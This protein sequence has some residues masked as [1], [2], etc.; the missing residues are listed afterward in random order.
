VSGAFHTLV[1]IDDVPV[2]AAL[3][4]LASAGWR[5]AGP[6]IWEDPTGAVIRL[7]NHPASGVQLIEVE[8]SEADEITRRIAAV[9]PTWTLDAVDRRVRHAAGPEIMLHAIRRLGLLPH[10]PP[11]N[12]AARGYVD[13]WSRTLHHPDRHVRLETLRA[14]RYRSP[15]LLRALLADAELDEPDNEV[16]AEIRRTLDTI[17]AAAAPP[18]DEKVLDDDLPF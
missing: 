10:P 18:D 12:G 6:T 16:Q 3:E 15:S 13:V 8:G 4:R 7:V 2:T 11:H 9:V 14:M 17:P 1:P 5:R